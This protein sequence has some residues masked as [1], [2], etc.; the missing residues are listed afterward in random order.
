M[1][2]SELLKAA[3][4]A[5]EKSGVPP[6]LQI[7]A[8]EQAVKLLS[9]EGKTNDPSGG[10]S[11]AAI[12]QPRANQDNDGGDDA[13]FFQRLA[14]ESGV[15]EADLRDLFHVDGDSIQIVVPTRDL[16]SS[17]SEQTRTVGTLI[18]SA[19]VHGLGSSL[20]EASVVSKVLSDKK[21][22]D[23]ANNASYMK[24]APGVAVVGSGKYAQ[25]KAKSTWHKDFVAA[26]GRVLKKPA[27]G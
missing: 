12:T 19:A 27:E 4:Q 6:Q 20:V 3:W 7:A 9:S 16:G 22:F 25:Y 23:S 24:L 5:V 14:R 13:L 21:C 15:A 1:E 2:T 11:G 26:V 17:T 8:F 10:P 18:V